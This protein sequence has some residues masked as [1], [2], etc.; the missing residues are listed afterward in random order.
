MLNITICIVCLHFSS[1]CCLSSVAD[2]LNT[3]ARAPTSAEHAP[4]LPARRVM[5]FMYVV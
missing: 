3:E 1:F 2:F 4:F 5:R